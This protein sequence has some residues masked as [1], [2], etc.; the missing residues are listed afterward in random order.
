MPDASRAGSQPHHPGAVQA[1]GRDQPGGGG[2]EFEG[3]GMTLRVDVLRGGLVGCREH[4]GAGQHDVASS[5]PEVRVGRG[6]ARAHHGDGDP[7]AGRESGQLVCAI[8]DQRI[9]RL[10]QQH[11]AGALA[12]LL[13]GVCGG[14][15]KG[16]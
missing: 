3:V 13:G 16:R 6:H 4:R 14:Q 12:A 2:A 15:L 1:A 11:G 10:G 5:H 7:S 8:S 9:G